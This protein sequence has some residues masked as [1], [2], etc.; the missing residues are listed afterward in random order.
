MDGAIVVVKRASLLPRRLIMATASTIENFGH[1]QHARIGARLLG[2]LV[3]AE[4]WIERHRQR[5]S[6][7]ALDDRMLHDIGL[8]HADVASEASKHFWEH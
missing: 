6:L 1:T 4:A 2:A 3:T 7:L 5:R 8:S